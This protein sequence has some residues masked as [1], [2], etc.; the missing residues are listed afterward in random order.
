MSTANRYARPV[1]E[2][3]WDIAGT[4]DTT[5]KWE[6]TD[7]RPALLSLYEKGKNL[8]W[9]T[10]SRI[11]WSQDL[12]PENPQAALHYCGASTEGRKGLDWTLEGTGMKMSELADT[13]SCLI[14][15]FTVVDRTGYTGT[16][17]AHLRWTPGMGEVGANGPASP[18]DVNESIFT[19]L[20]EQLGLKLKAGRGPVE[21]LVIDHAERP[22]AN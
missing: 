8:Q 6:Y 19:V 3:Q 12:D 10:N 9:N 7:G 20:Q 14:G 2:T 4:F 21:V 13:L 17:D 1:E 15:N 22:S 16:F 11:D 18:D 5:F